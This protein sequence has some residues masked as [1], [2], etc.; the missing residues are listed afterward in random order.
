MFKKILIANRGEIALRI[1]RTCAEN[2]IHSV[3]IYTETDQYSP[4]VKQANTS[5]FL[6]QNSKLG[7]LNKDQIIHIAVSQNCDAIHPGY[8]FLSENASFAQLCTNNKIAFIGPPPHL[9]KQMGNKPI[10]KALAITAGLATLPG[11]S[12]CSTLAEAL[13]AAEQVGFPLMLKATN[14]GGGKGIRFCKNVDDLQKYFSIVISEVENSFENTTVF[15]EKYV[16]QAQHIE[17]QIVADKYG[18]ICHLY[19]RNCSIQRRNQKLV[20]IAPSPNL[21]EQQKQKLYDWSIQYAKHIKYE[22]I[23]T[24]EFLRT[25]DNRFYFLEVN[26]RL[27]VEHPVT[28]SITGVDIVKEQI[29]ISFG[30]KL[31]FKQSTIHCSGIAMEFRINAE[32]PKNNFFP[33]AGYINHYF[34]PGGHGVRI[35]SAIYTGYFISTMYDSLCAKIIVWGQN[36]NDLLARAKRVMNEVEINGVK[37]TIPFYLNLLSHRDFIEQKF[38][39]DFLDKHLELVNYIDSSSSPYT[40]SIIAAACAYYMEHSNEYK[41]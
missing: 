17:V 39:I 28:E 30:K 27:Q 38:N 16:E 1:V 20:E 12:A 14:G 32:D 6:G 19:E 29:Q 21:D 2:N 8:G 18:N 25:N 10:A 11:S 24:I 23:G 33:E 37:T 3:A 41:S 9:I 31:S 36:W 22:N 7:Y 40:I 13:V 5:I 4:H 34:V 26:P 15:L 35:D